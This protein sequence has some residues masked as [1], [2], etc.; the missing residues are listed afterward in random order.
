MGGIA[1]LLAF[2]AASQG[3]DNGE[4]EEV[5][6]I[7]IISH[8]FFMQQVGQA[9]QLP[10]KTWCEFEHYYVLAPWHIELC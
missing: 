3:A 8:H 4:E 9:P 7:I 6:F 10:V 1:C 2:F 5:F